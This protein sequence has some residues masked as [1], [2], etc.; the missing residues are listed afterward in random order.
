LAEEP[1]PQSM[2]RLRACTQIVL[3]DAPADV[4][5]ADRGVLSPRTWRVP[6]VHTKLALLLAGVGWGALPQPML[7]PHLAAAR[8]VEL[9]P[10][11]WPEG[12]LIQMHAVTRADRPLGPAGRRLVA[13][14]HD[15]GEAVQ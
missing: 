15:A 2:G 12:H 14:L 5:A 7:E 13:A 8:L 11:P 10:E 6:D 9:E 4:E 1:A 3:A